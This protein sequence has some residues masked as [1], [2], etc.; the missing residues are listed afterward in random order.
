MVNV[1]GGDGV[2]IAV[3]AS[4]EPGTPTI[5]FVHGWAQSAYVWR[6]Q[7]ADPGLSAGRR[8]VAMD[9]RGHGRSGVPEGGYDNPRTWADDL[10]A[11]LQRA[12]TPAIVVGWSYGGLVIADYLRRY[13]DRGLAGLVFTG[14]ITEIGKHRPGGTIGHAM[15]GALPDAMSDDPDTA[16]PAVTGLCAGMAPDALPGALRQE[17]VGTTLAVPPAVR[18][19]LF[20]R[21][22][23]N[24]DVLSRVSIPTLVLHGAQDTVVA[25]AS[26]EYTAGKI[27]G[28]ELRCMPGVGHLPFIERTGEFNS[29]LR[30]FA[31]QHLPMS[32]A[33]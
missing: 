22:V 28:A 21:D 4:G 9:L 19:A 18:A 1:S 8:L 23:D 10:A 14:A 12:G 31:E 6:P 13:G 33:G 5:V 15:R 32:R 2:E 3:R 26:G 16:I 7:F 30:Q 20:K 29:V 27:T 24:S 11:V 25:P 17:L